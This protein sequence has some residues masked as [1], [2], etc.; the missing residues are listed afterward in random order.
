MWGKRKGGSKVVFKL[1]EIFLYRHYPKPHIT[2]GLKMNMDTAEQTLM[3]FG[4]PVLIEIQSPQITTESGVLHLDF[5][6]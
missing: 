6:I 2:K 1:P 5:A 3:P 4:V